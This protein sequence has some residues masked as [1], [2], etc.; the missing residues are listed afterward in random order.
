MSLP[1][2]ILAGGL[3]TRLHPFTERV[4]K[5]LVE[6]D[7]VPFIHHQLR[8]LRSRGIHRAVLC[9][10][11][12]GEAV[13][14]SVGDGSLF[15][16]EIDCTFDGP[17][18]RGTAGALRHALPLLGDAF[19][20]VYGD[21]YLPCDYQAVEASFRAQ[22]KPALMTVFRNEGQW[23]TSNVEFDGRRIL[24]YDKVNR[25]PAMRHID[26]GLGVLHRSA[27][28]AVPAAEPADLAGLYR[29]LLARDALA[30]LEISERFYEIGSFAGIRDLTAFLRTP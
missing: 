8:L 28:E 16:M 7:G 11:Y 17:V 12:L 15:G 9:L 24:A 23:D 19:F 30:A 25:T 6:I 20:V 29:D 27:F 1:A 2:A 13:R 22:D 4:P 26:Y 14:D 5:A 21:S 18:L 10:G 3:G